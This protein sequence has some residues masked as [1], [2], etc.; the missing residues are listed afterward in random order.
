[1][2]IKKLAQERM[3]FL[4]HAI[5]HGR[6]ALL[7]CLDKVTNQPVPVICVVEEDDDGEHLFP[8]GT[9]FDDMRPT[10]RYEPPP[11]G[12][13]TYDPDKAQDVCA[14]CKNQTTCPEYKKQEEEN[15]KKA[16]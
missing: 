15:K 1:M 2:A 12:V 3:E 6:V 8:I 16:N 7:E 4:A 10:G 13:E 5:A 11:G 14:S 9:I